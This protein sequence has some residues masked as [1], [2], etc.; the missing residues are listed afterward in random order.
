MKLTITIDM[1]NDAFDDGTGGYFEAA[2]IL[3]ELTAKLRSGN[4]IDGLYD[5]NGNKVGRVNVTQ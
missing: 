4:S 3:E 2:R 5:V 1:D